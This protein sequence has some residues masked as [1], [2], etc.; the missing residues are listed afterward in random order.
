MPDVR[1]VCNG[2]VAT[3]KMIEWFVSAATLGV[4]SVNLQQR[5]LP[6]P[7][8]RGLR[9][10]ECQ[11]PS[12]ELQVPLL[13]QNY[14]SKQVPKIG[15]APIKE[16]ASSQR[17]ST[18]FPAHQDRG[19]D[20][21]HVY[22]LERHRART[23]LPC[24]AIKHNTIGTMVAVWWEHFQGRPELTADLSYPIE[25]DSRCCLVETV[26]AGSGLDLFCERCR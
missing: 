3:G 12:K 24:E 14:T 16:S 8:S 13:C 7:A 25:K 18:I 6:L 17:A 23:T 26:T 5:I 4:L 20:M 10:S 9:Y 11:A 22:E 1:C 15:I 19:H 21:P 2:P